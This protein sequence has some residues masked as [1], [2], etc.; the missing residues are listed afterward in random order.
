MNESAE[1]LR[2]Q[3]RTVGI[4]DIRDSLPQVN[5]L[6]ANEFD[7]PY[8]VM[9][10]ALGFEDRLTLALE[11]LSRAGLRARRAVIIE[12]VTNQVD[13]ETNRDS[14]MAAL[15]SIGS[16]DV[17]T[18][19]FGDKFEEQFSRFIDES[20]S[21]NSRIVLDITAA[22][23]P[24]INR[25][26]LILMRRNLN[27]T[28]TYGEAAEYHP[29]AAEYEKGVQH[30]LSGISTAD[31]TYELEVTISSFAEQD[32]SLP[33]QVVIIPGFDT[34]RVRKVIAQVDPS[35]L[36]VNREPVIW[37]LGEPHLEKDRWRVDLMRKLHGIEQ[38]EDASRVLTASTFDYV[39]IWSLLDDIYHEHATTSRL[40]IAPMGSKLQAV[41]VVLFCLDR[42]DV[43]VVYA[44]PREY[45]TAR[46]T[47][48]LRDVWLI[49]V[50]DTGHLRRLVQSVGELTVG[51]GRETILAG[52]QRTDW[53]S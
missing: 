52:T 35:I 45:H 49:N 38:V 13:N 24:L 36:L 18:L 16:E 27:L 51:N 29:T 46:Y 37:I 21:E 1:E 41:G 50:S 15:A 40:S 11:Q 53:A 2:L 9:I 12:Y 28:L 22:S 44:T 26:L 34:D 31:G 32:D 8:D 4:G 48:G 10:L 23:N 39:S 17:A 33:D 5:R 19:D 43:K 42:P 47:T 3:V 20:I 14:V 25:A 6:E 30:D 7:S